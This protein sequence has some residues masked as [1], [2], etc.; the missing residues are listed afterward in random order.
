MRTSLIVA[1][2][3]HYNLRGLRG[4]CWGSLPDTRAAWWTRF[5]MRVADIQFL[6]SGYPHRAGDHGPVG[7]RGWSRSSWPSASANW[8][9]FARPARGSTLMEKEKGLRGRSQA[10]GHVPPCGS[11]WGRSCPTS[12]PRSSSSPRYASPT[13]SSWN[14]PSVFLG[15]GRTSDRALSGLLDQQRI[16]RSCSAVTGG[17]RSSPGWP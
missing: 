7:P 17:S 16:T 8:V 9:F 1:L 3:L 15:V 2:S 10:G 11:C 6:L 12:W 4:V 14:P 5:I 13:P